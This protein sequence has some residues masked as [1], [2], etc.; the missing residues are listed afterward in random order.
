LATGRGGSNVKQK[1]G[2]L[3]YGEQGTWKSSLALQFIKFKRED[4]KPFRILFIDPEQGSI[5]SYLEM[6]ENEGIDLTNIYIV[7][8]Q[9]LTETNEYI[10]R[11]RNNEDFYVFDEETGE[12]TDEVYMDSDGKPFRPDAIV[13]DG[14]S[15]LYTA[16]QQGILE[17]SKKRA[18]VRANKKE[19]VGMEKSVAIEGAGLEIKDYNTLRFDGQNLILNLLASDRHFAVT[20]REEDEKEQYEDKT[21][22]IKMKATGRKQPTGFKD[23]RYNVKTV[24]HLFKDDDGSVKG[25]IENKDRTMV[26]SQDELLEEPTLLDW[27]IV[28]DRNKGKKEY[29]H[30]N[31][32]NKSVNIERQSIEEDN[33]KFDQDYEL[34]KDERRDGE[35]QS[36]QDYHDRITKEISGIKQTQKAKCLAKLKSEDIPQIFSRITDIEVLKKYLEIVQQFS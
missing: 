20:C 25:I 18:T 5:D 17:F 26:H 6:Y 10:N 14:V 28:I 9:S 11:A 36:P 31:N 33:A 13:V 15:L 23:V 27:Q 7:Y 30:S 24:I 8:T 1:L 21:G 29:K 32:L 22:E 4:G 35:L 3:L 2:F 12:E 34:S 16:R 19:L